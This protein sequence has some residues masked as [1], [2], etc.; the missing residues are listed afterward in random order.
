[1]LRKI[2]LIV[3]FAVFLLGCDGDFEQGKCDEGFFEQSNF[4]GN[5][6]SYCVPIGEKESIENTISTT[7]NLNELD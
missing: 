6:G 7:E 3:I 5:G 2:A 1:M 4:Q